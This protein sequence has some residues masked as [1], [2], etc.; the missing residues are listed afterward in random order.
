[1]RTPF[2]EYGGKRMTG[3]KIKNTGMGF[4]HESF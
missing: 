4:A 3:M 2:Q 1:M